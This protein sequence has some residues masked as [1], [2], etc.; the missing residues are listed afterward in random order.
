[1]NE[2]AAR[3]AIVAEALT[4]EGTPYHP[5][6]RVKGVGCDCAQLPAA[7]YEAVGLIEPVNPTYTSD[8]MLHRDEEKF[9]GFVLPQARQIKFKDVQPGD[10]ILWRFGRTFSH[11]AIVLDMPEVLHA[12]LKGGAVIRADVTR[13]SD[14]RDRECRY[15][16]IFGRKGKR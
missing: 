10:L 2:A 15:F 6:A 12:A 14:L 9:L 7:V 3:A 5:H 11:A 16:S 8:W 1:M 13:E 4:W